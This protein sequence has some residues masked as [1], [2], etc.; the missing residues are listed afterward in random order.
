M[1]QQMEA[2][3]RILEAVSFESLVVLALVMHVL[4]IALARPPGARPLAITCGCAL[5]VIWLTAAVLTGGLTDPS[6]LLSVLMRGMLLAVIATGSLT[7][8]FGFCQSVYRRFDGSFIRPFRSWRE[9]RRGKRARRDELKR[10]KAED[11]RLL[12]EQRLA[13]PQQRRAA[14]LAHR[15]DAI[16]HVEQLHRDQVRFDVRLFYDRYRREL[17]ELLPEEKFAA[18]FQSFLT[19]STDADVF[20]QRAE[21]LKDM[22]RERLELSSHNQP[23]TFESIDQVIAH[24]NEKRRVISLL[25]VDDETLEEFQIDLDESMKSD[26]KEFL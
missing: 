3:I 21:R 13:A 10:R 6:H 14:E 8:V 11:E 20:E 18:Y 24:Y 1:H 9:R 16:A 2:I 26:L 22:I 25:P 5:F 17:A 7:L 12:E 19:D 15:Q 23:V 4:G